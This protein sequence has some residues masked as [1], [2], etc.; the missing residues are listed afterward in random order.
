MTKRFFFLVITL[1]ATNTYSNK[2][3]DS[4][5][6]QLVTQQ[7]KEYMN[8]A[9]KIA[10]EF[11]Y[12]TKT[13]SISHYS[14]ISFREAEK[15]NDPVVKMKSS[16]YWASGLYSAGKTSESR[17]K[18]KKVLTYAH[19]L[20][21][22]NEIVQHHYMLARTY[23]KDADYNLAIDW[24][25]KAYFKS[26]KMVKSGTAS[27]QIKAYCKAILRQLAYTYV[28][29]TRR[30]DGENFFL[31]EIKNIDASIPSDIKRSY[32]S[33][34]SHIY[35]QGL[36][37]PKAVEYSKKALEISLKSDNKTDQLQDYIYV[38]VALA[39]YN[40]EESNKYLLKSLEYL[41]SPKYERTRAWAYSNLSKNFNTLGKLNE[42]IKY[43][44]KGID[45]QKKNK[46]SLGLSY[47]YVNLGRKLFIWRDY[48]SS[49]D[50]LFKAYSYFKKKKLKKKI[51]ESASLLAY[52][53][54]IT[55][56]KEKAKRYINDLK[57]ISDELKNS[58]N[59]GFYYSYQALYELKIDKEYD[60]A[61]TNYTNAIS[62]FKKISDERNLSY[63]YAFISEACFE[64]KNYS[65]SKKYAYKALN[66]VKKNNQIQIERTIVQTLN[67][68]YENEN[69][70]D[71]AY[72]YIK[73]LKS[74]DDKLFKR[75][76]TLAMY[77]KQKEYEL[78]DEKEK[79]EVLENSHNK[80]WKSATQYKY[81]LY[82]LFTII[83]IVAFIVYRIRSSNHKKAILKKEKENELINN[84]FEAS[85]LKIEKFSEELEEKE[86]EFNKLKNDVS[87]ADII[88]E[89]KISN[90]ESNT[91]NIDELHKSLQS[92]L[93][94]EEQWGEFFS[95]FGRVFPDFIN[96]L[97]IKYPKLSKS[98]IK[99]FVLM[100][101]NLPAKEISRIL[102]IS[103]SSLMTS[104]Y[105]I[106]KKLNLSSDD[107][108]EDIL[109]I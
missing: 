68:I 15:Y 73:K 19:S 30:K 100:K 42:S 32:Y 95:S 2:L 105:R 22:K 71:S 24:F 106:R 31:T 90:H 50:Y 17:N 59:I 12:G 40:S 89:K 14:S 46:D 98:D 75:D 93:V 16:L 44:Y 11:S 4:L 109:N 7:G 96:K 9:L 38:A 36:N 85:K 60:K 67:K 48:K 91:I 99:I 6:N 35:S 86:E 34:L 5:R 82:F 69:N 8:T 10:E 21:R 23:Q 104:R 61:I 58:R 20:N 87:I 103:T 64:N 97:N 80:L 1:F 79:S 88:P 56:K 33:D 94:T 70:Q 77:K 101:L 45:I 65:E 66:L 27:R 41:K 81:L 55:N 39:N 54:I 29:G 25:K 37:H 3:I 62:Q 78:A 74:V 92:E 84:R 83:T 102:M 43:Q 28:Y 52:I 72:V 13:D 57:H 51:S 18:L 53:S 47:S 76:A 49:E 107:K 63:C 108:L 26:L